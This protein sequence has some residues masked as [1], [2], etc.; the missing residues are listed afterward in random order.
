LLAALHWVTFYGS[1]KYAN[2]SVGLV[3][4]SAI[5]FFTAFLEPLINKKSINIIEVLLGLLVMIGIYIIFHFDPQYKTGII[6]GITSALLIAFVMI[7]IR[8]FVQRINSETLLTYQLT[9]G[10]I[11]LSA[12]MPFYLSYFP[13]QAILPGWENLGWL[14]ILSWFCSVWAFQLSAQALK[15]LSAFTVNLTYNLEPIYGIALAFVFYN[16]AKELSSGFYYGLALI[17][18]AVVLQMWRVIKLKKH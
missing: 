12:L 7:F 9:G 1:I 17:I 13:V 11:M 5:G 3:C 15:K 2:I 10:F 4:F 16:E 14:F 8:Q 6:L 18:L